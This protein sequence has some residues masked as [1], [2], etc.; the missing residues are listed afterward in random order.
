MTGQCPVGESKSS[1]WPGFVDNGNDPAGVQP[2]DTD[3]SR[4]DCNHFA[5]LDQGIP[6]AGL[7]PAKP[8]LIPP[9]QR[10]CRGVK[11]LLAAAELDSRVIDDIPPGKGSRS[12][13]NGSIRE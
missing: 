1:D 3:R 10:C 8:E 7:D 6:G 9:P 13:S 2:P 11:N 12:G 4:N 5:C